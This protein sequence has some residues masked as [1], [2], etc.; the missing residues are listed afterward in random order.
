MSVT[1]RRGRA[2]VIWEREGGGCGARKRNAAQRSTSTSTV[3]T[4]NT[5]SL[6][7]HIDH[8]RNA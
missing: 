3:C 6:H 8:R 1:E 5:N 7:H 2:W 4:T